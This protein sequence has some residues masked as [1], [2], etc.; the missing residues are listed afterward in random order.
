M[1]TPR[2]LRRGMSWTDRKRRMIV[3]KLLT[4]ILFLVCFVFLVN[5]GIK[6]AEIRYS[7][8]HNEMMWEVPHT[9]GIIWKYLWEGDWEVNKKK[10]LYPEVRFIYDCANHLK[11]GQ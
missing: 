9:G 5:E 1:P 4:V 11:Y 7:G 8:Y 10:L 6:P 3:G 2:K